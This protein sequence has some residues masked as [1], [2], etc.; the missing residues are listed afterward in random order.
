M[1]YPPRHHQEANLDNIIRTIEAFPLAT[2]ISAE[3]SKIYTTHIPLIYENTGTGLG[4]LVGHLDKFNPHCDFLKDELEC[5]VVFHG[6]QTYISPSIYS[7][8][9]LPTWNY[10]KVHLKGKVTRIH[11]AET[12]KNSLVNMTS[13]LE[14]ERQ[15][16]VL[17]K[18]DSRMDAL[19]DYI[20]GFEIEITS[21]EGKF[22]LSQDKNIK[23]RDLAK[24][25]LLN[26][27]PD[28]KHEFIEQIYKNHETP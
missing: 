18:D 4:K 12:V 13:A 15:A 5:T 6:P 28:S 22:K 1:N 20:I 16:Y 24:Q 8:R 17:D 7:T 14:G 2:V 21:W 3:G 27:E 25:A 19:I 10:I 11:D 9:Q 26:S 23:D